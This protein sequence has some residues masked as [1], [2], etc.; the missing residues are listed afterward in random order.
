M[1]KNSPIIGEF[2]CNDEKKFETYY[3]ELTSL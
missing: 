2:F 3:G 1:L